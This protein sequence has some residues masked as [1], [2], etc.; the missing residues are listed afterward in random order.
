MCSRQVLN[1][2][3]PFSVLIHTVLSLRNPSG[4]T[5]EDIYNQLTTIC[6]DN[7]WSYDDTALYTHRA[8]N[9]GILTTTTSLTLYAVNA[10]MARV[11][12]ANAPYYCVGQLYTC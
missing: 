4:V 8:M 5:I 11:N 2:A 6:P 3:D 9:R 1:C 10:A 7:T 12:P